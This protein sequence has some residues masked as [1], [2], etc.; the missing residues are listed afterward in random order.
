[1]VRRSYNVHE[2]DPTIRM[3]SGDGTAEDVTVP[4]ALISAADAAVVLDTLRQAR[5]AHHVAT[6]AAG[7]VWVLFS[8]SGAC[9]GLEATSSDAA[10][11]DDAQHP[12]AG[13]L[14]RPTPLL[15]HTLTCG[16]VSPCSWRRAHRV[17]WRCR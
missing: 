8:A 1:M 14:F 4:A 2:R 5:A 10:T 16:P 17:L 15:S 6:G 9:Q 3:P 12:A 13:T 11:D 7:A